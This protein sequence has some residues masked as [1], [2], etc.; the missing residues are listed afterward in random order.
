MLQYTSQSLSFCDCFVPRNDTIHS[1]YVIASVAK[2]SQSLV[3]MLQYVS[4]VY[5][6]GYLPN[7]ASKHQIFHPY[8]I[9][10][11]ELK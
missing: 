3:K 10:T 4:A 11:I 5:M 6:S 8:F 2:Q 7:P 9:L 1:K